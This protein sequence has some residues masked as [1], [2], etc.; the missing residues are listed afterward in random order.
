VIRILDVD[1]TSHRS[2]RS[3][4]QWSRI[5]SACF[6]F[7]WPPPRVRRAWLPMLEDAAGRAP[8]GVAIDP[9]EVGLD[10]HGT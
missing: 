9:I 1:E 10:E 6:S 7:A 2:T 5:G 3:T 4:A 8:V